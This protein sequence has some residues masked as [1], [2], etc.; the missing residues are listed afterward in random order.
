MDVEPSA[1]TDPASI[2]IGLGAVCGLF[3]AGWWAKV[4]KSIDTS[5]A[6]VKGPD[7]RR[8]GEAAAIT[9]LC[10]GLASFGYLLGRYTGRF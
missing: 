10:I 8:L 7:L 4:A 1:I 9:A 6:S 2:L 5:G 3:A